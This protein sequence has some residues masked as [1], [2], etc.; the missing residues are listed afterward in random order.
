MELE[1]C[2]LLG[3][4]EKNA[5]NGEGPGTEELVNGCL[6]YAL[7]AE[8]YQ[9]T[10]D[11]MLS[12]IGGTFQCARAYIFEVNKNNT[13]SNT[14]EW[15]AP[16]SESQKDLLQNE[17]SDTLSWWMKSFQSGKLVV[18]D[19]IEEIKEEYSSVYA[20]L[21][22]QGIRRL[23]A[24][25]LRSDGEVIGFLGVDNPQRH[26][27]RGLQHFLCLL[28]HF[29]VSFIKR[30]DLSYRL[31]Y[32]SYHDQL[33]GALNRSA[34]KEKEKTLGG[35]VQVGIL[36]GDITGL[37]RQNDLFG[38]AAGDAMICQCYKMINREFD[39]DMIY[40]MG[41]DE[42]L[43]IYAGVGCQ[44]F[45]K[46]C[47]RLRE[48]INRGDYHLAVGISWGNLQEYPLHLLV[49]RAEEEMYK[50]KQDYY[51]RTHYMARFYEEKEAG[52][53]SDRR[54]RAMGGVESLQQYLQSTP[55]SIGA[56]IESTELSNSPICLYLGDLQT[57][58][59]YISNNMR[60][61]FGFE[62][63]QVY[64]LLD[65]WERRICHKEDLESYRQDIRN[66][67]NNTQREHDFKYR[68]YDK[69]GKLIWIHCR[70]I[71]Y[72]DKNN[73]P[74]YFAGFVS[75]PEFSIDPV[76]NLPRESAAIS[77]LEM[78]QERGKDTIVLGIGLNHFTEINETK[79]RAAAD[80]LLE[81]I[82]VCWENRMSNK[83]WFYRLD[84]VS[85]MAVV[86]PECTEE[87]ESLVAEIREGVKYYYKKWNV[88]VKFPCSFC[89]FHYPSDI[90][91]PEFF[92]GKINPLIE[93]AKAE[94]EKSYISYSARTVDKYRES[95]GMM[96]QLSEDVLN[97]FC[98]FRVVIQ[99]IVSAGS[100]EVEGGEVLLRWKYRGED[101]C[102]SVFVPLLEKKGLIKQTGRWVFRETV[103]HCARIIPDYPAFHL[104]F[105]VSY[106]QVVGEDF[107]PFMEEML[108]KYRIGGEN[109]VMELTENHFDEEPEKLTQFLDG[110]RRLGMSIA[111]DDFGSGYSSMGLLIKYPSNLVKLDRSLLNGLTESKDK[112]T[113]LKTVIF[114]CHQFGKKVCAEGVEGPEEAR[115]VR[116]TG[117]DMIQGYYFYKPLELEEFY[118][119][120]NAC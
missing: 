111:L 27:V 46:K 103:R 72:R 50:D 5:E 62:S 11:R 67:W 68:V 104:S 51:R 120:L 36:Y 86:K 35:N 34:Y 14:Y 90:P 57:N 1:R 20:A 25:P 31:S 45:Q 89:V 105:N 88:L 26:Q 101:I 95:A 112:Q 64:N 33:T 37:K 75:K 66:I 108:E 9:D 113:F 74:L 94:R 85:F 106:L 42:F 40:R 54:R 41:G 116:E 117:S 76:T 12:Y 6:Q 98:N 87:V 4:D 47:S 8:S 102:P 32:V 99:P 55:D 83:A 48:T 81:D 115:I 16:G 63:N 84:G 15:C 10:F 24:C 19:D 82:S 100:G 91:K 77:K 44:Q 53:R 17:P 78:L 73:K 70:G 114:A 23:V 118:K 39:R 18:I 119:M 107:V 61:M 49:N 21:K 22:P 97:G 30:R 80:A 60:E 13:F 38:H 2:T 43:V 71:L 69:D 93:M 59:F 3:K 29:A 110:C 7:G 58:V 28:E 96:L 109:L 56:L 79:G 65:K 92:L 52:G